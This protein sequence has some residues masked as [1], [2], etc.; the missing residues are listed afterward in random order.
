L[1]EASARRHPF[2][3]LNI[4]TADQCVLA[5]EVRD[6]LSEILTTMRYERAACALRAQR[7]YEMRF[8]AWTDGRTRTALL[9]N[10]TPAYQMH[11]QTEFLIPPAAFDPEGPL[12]R[13]H[14]RGRLDIE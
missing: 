9:R 13:P 7:R 12:G 11:D 4:D 3:A 14:T 5:S 10:N 1:S 6:S 8:P 2:R